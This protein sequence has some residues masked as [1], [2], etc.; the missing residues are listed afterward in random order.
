[1]TTITPKNMM[2]F[3]YDIEKFMPIMTDGRAVVTHIE[4]SEGAI[5]HHQR[6]ITPWIVA[7]RSVFV[8]TY[9][10]HP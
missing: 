3:G 9:N 8:T 7:N 6:M 1:M 10:M 4:E 5:T 2:T